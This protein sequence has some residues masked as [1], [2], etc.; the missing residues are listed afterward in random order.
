MILILCASLAQAGRFD[1]AAPQERGAGWVYLGGG[2]S[3]FSS[4]FWGTNEFELPASFSIAR[5]DLIGEVGLGPHLAIGAHVP[6]VDST[7]IVKVERLCTTY[8]MCDDVRSFGDLRLGLRSPWQVQDWTITGRVEVASGFAYQ[9]NIDDLGA[10][11]DGN[12]DLVL[13][14]MAGRGGQL[15]STSYKVAGGVEWEQAFGR[16]PNAIQGGLEASWRWQNLELGLAWTAYESLGGLSFGE[17]TTND[18]MENDPG[19]FTDIDNDVQTMAPRLSVYAGERVGVHT[20]A[21]WVFA[22]D[23]GPGDLTGANL[24]VSTW[25]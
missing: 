2:I 8:G 17:A 19:R 13:G 16:P 11:G 24:G 22:V 12:T 6:W 15:G 23:S 1:P 14:V 20:G 4:E 10:P 9:A 18:R 3:S 21:W 7:A 25:W 5:A